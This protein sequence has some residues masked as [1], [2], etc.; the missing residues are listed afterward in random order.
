MRKQILILGKQRFGIALNYG[1]LS[2]LVKMLNKIHYKS[3]T[4]VVLLLNH[5]YLGS[6]E[7]Q[8]RCL[9]VEK[10]QFGQTGSIQLRVDQVAQTKYVHCW[11]LQKWFG[12]FILGTRSDHWYLFGELF[13]CLRLFWKHI[14]AVLRCT[15]FNAYTSLLY[16]QN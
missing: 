1:D 16:Q 11:G 10:H 3:R 9:G 12:I 4:V 13:V 15:D 5:R 6:P 2:L 8:K 14:N 7:V